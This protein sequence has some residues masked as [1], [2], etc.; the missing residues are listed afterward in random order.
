[1]KRNT[2]KT[3]ILRRAAIL[4]LVAVFTTTGAW[5]QSSSTFGGGDGS[6]Q[7]PYII[8]TAEHWNQF[9]SDVNGGNTYSDKYFLLDADITITTMVGAG[10]DR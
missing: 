5:A 9:A 4:L 3:A 6:A 10:N 1:M 8:K 2:A 7:N